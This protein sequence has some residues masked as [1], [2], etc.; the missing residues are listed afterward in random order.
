MPL[1]IED[2]VNI[3]R[4]YVQLEVKL[5]NDINRSTLTF[6]T[7]AELIPE[8]HAAHANPT[9]ALPNLSSVLHDYTPLPHEAL[10]LGVANDSLPV[11]L[12][13]RDPVPGPVLIAG[14]PESGKT[15]LLQII[16]RAID[17]R[18]NPENIRFAVITEEIRDWE[19][20]DQ[21]SN[22]EG[23]LSFNQPLTT[24]YLDSLVEWAHNNK[25]DKQFI[26]LLVD[27]MEALTADKEIHQIFRWLLLRGPARRIWPIVT[28]DAAHSLDVNP[29]LESFRTRLCG[30][31]TSEK[32]IQLLTGSTSFI[33]RDLIAGS[34]FSMRES[35]DWLPFWLPNLD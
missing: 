32:N 17:H 14:D 23:I 2:K 24:N 20:L 28:L 4:T 9:A 27:G 22:C 25:H 3:I 18:H 12:N 29:W 10:F 11:L 31:I 35:R 30:H 8:I 33:F 34:Q 1:D 15:K 13:L 26:L 7:M 5:M 16:A 21:S 6:E 19:G